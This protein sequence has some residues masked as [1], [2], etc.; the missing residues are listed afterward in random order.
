MNT[1]KIP[2]GPASKLKLC[3][4]N[5]QLKNGIVPKEFQYNNTYKT[6]EYFLNQFPKGFESLPGFDQIIDK[7]I[8]ESDTPLNE[9]IS[10]Q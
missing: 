6:R 1:K 8:E 7:L 2:L 9:L 5:E 4:I 10:H 3:E